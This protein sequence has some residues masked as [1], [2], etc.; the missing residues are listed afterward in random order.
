MIKKI[1]KGFTLV[2]MV[3][4][5]AV[6]GILAAVLIP[7]FSNVIQNARYSSDVS[8]AKNMSTIC[9][10]AAVG[11]P[12]DADGNV[13]DVN[14]NEVS[15]VVTL[16]QANNYTLVPESSGTSFWYNRETGD[17]E[18]IYNEDMFACDDVAVT[19]SDFEQDCIE[20]M[21]RS[22]PEHVII[23]RNPENPVVQAIDTV[24]SIASDAEDASLTVDA[25][26][27]VSS[28]VS[29]NVDS[30]SQSQL[31][32]SKQLTSVAMADVDVT[33]DAW[34]NITQ[35]MQD[36]F[37][38]ATTTTDFKDL[39]YT[40]EDQKSFSPVY[41]YL[42]N[43]SPET[44]Y[45]VGQYG[46]YT[47]QDTGTSGTYNFVNCVFDTKATTF[48]TFKGDSSASMTFENSINIPSTITDFETG[49]LSAA[50]SSTVVVITNTT[51]DTVNLNKL[52]YVTI[53]DK[54]GTVSVT[55][56]SLEYDAYEYNQ[57][58][59][60]YN[61][62]TATTTSEEVTSADETVDT[63]STTTITTNYLDLYSD[64]VTKEQGSGTYVLPTYSEIKTDDETYY[65]KNDSSIPTDESYKLVKSIYAVPTVTL[66]TCVSDS[67]ILNAEKILDGD[68]TMRVFSKN[69]ANITV[70]Y[71]VIITDEVT[72]RIEEMAYVKN[73]SVTTQTT[74][75][76]SIYCISDPFAGIEY[77]NMLGMTITAYTASGDSASVSKATTG[78]FKGDYTISN[79]QINEEDIKYFIVQDS[80]GNQIL[81]QYI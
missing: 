61:Q 79:E 6:I 12:T 44:S 67:S 58:G 15:G 13:I 34:T 35:T 62:Y 64:L 76:G 71:G 46:A 25:D 43:Y 80:S 20:A 5:I 4:V 78:T 49:C 37:D 70:I 81:K 42:N 8:A 57:Y 75:S 39:F 21:V 41:T 26:G 10:I 73:L 66:D 28:N 53:V 11:T 48:T 22:K 9:K 18:I 54:T 32:A 74:S 72:Y 19:E 2:E 47:S 33:S 60:V 63:T 1:K 77:Y 52:G 7:V 38:N 59:V 27:N 31:M 17:V 51:Y 68:H 23:D 30:Y 50:D 45:Y 36:D 14:M 65:E 29:Y 55:Y 3:I 40:D 56:T 69:L 24:Y 16:L